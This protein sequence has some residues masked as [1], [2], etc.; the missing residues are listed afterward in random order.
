MAQGLWYYGNDLLASC[1][2]S[3]ALDGKTA[4][5]LHKAMIAKMKSLYI[6][7][8]PIVLYQV[9]VLMDALG[10]A[11]AATMF[12]SFLEGQSKF[13]PDSLETIFLKAMQW[14]RD[15]PAAISDARKR[16][17]IR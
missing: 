5:A 3:D 17:R 12:S 16:L 1:R 11:D 14:D 9:G 6:F 10:E 4:D 7:P 2:F 15:T 8:L 13:T